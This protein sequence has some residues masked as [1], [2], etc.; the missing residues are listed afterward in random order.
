[1]VLITLLQEDNIHLMG[2]YQFD[3]SIV[4]IKNVPQRTIAIPDQRFLKP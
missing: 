3:D 2:L 4:N 1:M